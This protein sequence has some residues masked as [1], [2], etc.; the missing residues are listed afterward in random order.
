MNIDFKS[1]QFSAALKN[2]VDFV[3]TNKSYDKYISAHKSALRIIIS[4]E[5]FVCCPFLIFKVIHA[6][7]T[8][9]SIPEGFGITETWCIIIIVGVWALVYIE[10]IT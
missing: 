5:R 10:D 1:Y 8:S 3:K 2:V 6:H 9:H 7:V 4:L